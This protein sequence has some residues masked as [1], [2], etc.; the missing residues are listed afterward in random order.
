ML[1][2][3]HLPQESKTV[4]AFIMK[5]QKKHTWIGNVAA[6]IV[7]YIVMLAVCYLLIIYLS[8]AIQWLLPDEYYNNNILAS[9]IAVLLLML[10]IVLYNWFIKI[11]STPWRSILILDHRAKITYI[12][13]HRQL[14]KKN[15]KE[16]NATAL[17]DLVQLRQDGLVDP[18]HID[19][20]TAGLD[21]VGTSLKRANLQGAN[22]QEANLQR[23]TLRRADLQEANLQ[24]ATLLRAD[25]QG[26]TLQGADLQG[27]T[28]QMADLQEADMSEANLYEA[29]LQDAKG[30]TPGMLRK[31]K[32]WRDAILDP[33]MRQQAEEADRAD[34]E[35]G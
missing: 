4:T 28:L 35:P 13:A 16:A 33:T 34:E 11:R 18:A 1:S 17:T 21:L 6:I 3:V 2:L 23:A 30:L 12:N 29:D 26:A 5:S 19:T 32:N 25:L 15:D 9:A 24:R 31:A 8:D 14:A 20:M 7:F 22:L 10:P 27:A